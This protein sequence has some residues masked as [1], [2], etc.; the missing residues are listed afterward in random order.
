M[1]VLHRAAP[2]WKVAPCHH[3]TVDLRLNV[4]RRSRELAFV[5]KNNRG[6]YEVLRVAPLVRPAHLGSDS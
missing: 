3:P 6:D 5:D 4:G 2:D 1:A